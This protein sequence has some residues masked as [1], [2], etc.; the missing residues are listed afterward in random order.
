M[1][2]LWGLPCQ[3][4]LHQMTFQGS[5][6]NGPLPSKSPHLTAGQLKSSA[7]NV[8]VLGIVKINSEHLFS[9]PSLFPTVDFG[10]H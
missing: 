3:L 6:D 4:G 9:R 8:C 10:H 5:K 2:W 1:S 7:E